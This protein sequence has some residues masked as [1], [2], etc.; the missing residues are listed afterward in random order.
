MPPFAVIL[1]AAGRS[2]RFGRD[3]LLEPLAGVPVFRRSI[4]AF[5]HRGDIARIVVA[6]DNPHLPPLTRDAAVTYCPGGQ[7]RAHSVL[8]ALRSIGD[9]IDWVS[10]HDA[11]RP[12][13]SQ[14]LIDRT[15][16]AAADHGA[17]A[18]AL[19]VQ[20]TLKQAGPLPARV[21]R[22]IPRQNLW[23]MQTPQIARRSDLLDAFERC[24]L[25]LDQIT[26][27]L[28]LLELTG[29]DVWL[30]EGEQRNIKITTPLDLRLAEV[31]L[32]DTSIG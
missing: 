28:Q 22:T 11:A 27:D 13:V 4:D 10:I 21:E 23:A 12:L 32:S 17:A 31:L 1:P 8:S 30:I 7:T 20:L 15:L 25:P 29:H 18:P 9:D 3:K 5:A 26:D 24:P 14:E 6:T 19:P 16:A 2:T